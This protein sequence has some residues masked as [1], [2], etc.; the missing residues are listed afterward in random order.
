MPILDLRDIGTR[1]GPRVGGKAAALARLVR[2]GFP[3]PSGFVITAEEKEM[4]PALAGELRQRAEELGPRVAVRSSAVGE[5]AEQTFAGQYETVLGVTPGDETERAVRACWA[6]AGSER[7]RT[8]R[9]RRGPMAVIVQRQVASR[10]AGVLFTVNPTTGSWSEMVIEAAWGQGE[11]VVSGR[12]VP[13][14]YVVPRRF[15]RIR[16]MQSNVH[17]QT[18]ETIIDAGGRREVEV[19]SSRVGTPKL[20]RS[21]VREL[22]RLGL[23]IEKA[24]GE[25]QDIEWAQEDGRFL[26]LQARPITRHASVRRSREA[27]L[28]TRRFL[29]ERWTEP[30][31]PLGWSN[32]EPILAHFIAYPATS[33]RLLSGEPPMRL[34]RF[35]P[36]VDAT[37]FRHLLF[38]FPGAAPPR[39]LLEMLPPGEVEAWRRHRAQA[40]DVAVYASILGETI[41][42]Q[43]WRR[44][45]WNPATNWKAWD[46]FLARADAALE[47]LAPIAAPGE[48]LARAAAMRELVRD[49]VKVHIAS[50]LFANI[51]YETAEAALREDAGGWLRP[52]AETWTARTNRALWHLGR[53]LLSEADF[54]E[55]FGHRARSSWELM[56]PRWAEA[57]P[58]TL[59]ARLAEGP[60]PVA[61]VGRDPAE[62]PLPVRP[63]VAMAQRYLQ[64]REDQRF[65]F[66]RLMWEWKKAYVWLGT[67]LGTDVRFL[68]GA[69]LDRVVAG[70]LDP[71]PLIDRR[72]KAWEDEAARREAGDEPPDFLG[73][74]EDPAI[75]GRLVGS[76]ISP[77]VATGPVRIV[78][79]VEGAV[80]EAGEILVLRA[81]EPA[82]TPLFV[83]ASGLVMELGGALSHGAIVAREY[84]LPAVAN[85]AGAMQRL[86]DGQVVTVDGNRGIVWL[87]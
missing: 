1:D 60:E 49:Y 35:A 41:R 34:Y 81:A 69:E 68:E 2:A 38:K 45:R 86:K 28:W 23:A 36:Y 17:A 50:L 74:E 22:C 83:R 47:A 10:C 4:T 37:V 67:A 40:P 24:L 14:G 70:T 55:R 85:V 76:A 59:A 29:G 13:D 82:S 7:A 8:Y 26:V 48:A 5:D 79:N 65:H 52:R 58:R 57:P 32:L 80:L 43:R 25:P 54:L 71:D 53:G 61:E 75:G 77:G 39:F 6:S 84:E 63:L 56:S 16:D 18:V 72:R 15:G 46:A 9:G 62:L 3:V 73:E 19:P 27:A 31:T 51:W 30:A 11:S 20:R 78:R 64:L 33:R 42:E 21:E 87:R 66:D 44:F 12:V